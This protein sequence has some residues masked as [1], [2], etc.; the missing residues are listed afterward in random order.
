[1][2]DPGHIYEIPV[3]IRL[4]R[5]TPM[6]D[7]AGLGK[8]DPH[9]MT[10]LTPHPEVPAVEEEAVL[11][12]TS[13]HPDRAE[14]T[15]DPYPFFDR[16]RAHAP[17]YRTSPGPVLVTSYAETQALIRDR[18]WSRDE[19]DA[20]SGITPT[21]GL[22]LESLAFRDPPDHTRLR[23]LVS[24]LFTPRAVERSRGYVSEIVS[25]LLT[26]LRDRDE[27]DFI[28]DFAY[29]VPLQLI[30]RL[31]GIPTET[32]QR[33]L[34]WGGALHGAL[35][36]LPQ[37]P[38]VAARREAAAR[39]CFDYF[40]ALIRERR[41]HPG[42]SD[43][44]SQLI[45]AD[46]DDAAEESLTDDEIIANCMLLHSAGFST[47]KN[48]ISNGM[49]L[50]ITHPD[51]YDDMR[52]HPDVIPSAVEEILRYEGPA[53]NSL[54]RIAPEEI[55]LG[56]VTIAPGEHVYAIL[57]AANRDPAAFPDPH[58][59]DIRRDGTRQVAFGGGIHLCLGAALARLEAAVAFTHLAGERRLELATDE[60]SW[61]DGFLTR[62][63]VSF[64]VRWVR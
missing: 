53:R 39:E 18:R 26:G 63:L 25:G 42:G 49:Y 22:F 43:I 3:I 2:C 36:P 29:R 1:M 10:T 8:E 56:G 55:E 13:G 14:I 6:V 41:A 37:S 20:R 58:R 62:G 28:E 15:R 52:A 59:F 27:F 12:L 9:R 44:I 33:F 11:Y 64:P 17:V 23:G 24:R 48:L 46:A 51:A 19:I 31:I 4:T 16:L 54:L 61:L 47:T 38:E 7:S 60:V 32:E 30:C 34:T 40:A 50:F 21:Q 57:S 35:E 45:E 5:N